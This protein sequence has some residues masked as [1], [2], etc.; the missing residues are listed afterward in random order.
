MSDVGKSDLNRVSIFVDRQI[1][2]LDESDGFGFR[3]PGLFGDGA[4]EVAPALELAVMEVAVVVVFQRGRAAD[5]ASG[6]DVGAGLVV[7]FHNRGVRGAIFLVLSAH[8]ALLLP[9]PPGG[10]GS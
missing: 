9:V 7:V 6:L 5:A 1:E 4:R 3:E 2:I 8:F 10:T